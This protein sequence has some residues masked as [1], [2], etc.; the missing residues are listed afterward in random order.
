[1]WDDS[2]DD[3]EYQFDR[4]RHALAQL[5]QARGEGHAAA[6]VAVSHY[7]TDY[8]GDGK[9]NVILAV[10]AELYDI[11]REELSESLKDG[12][13]DIVGREAFDRITFRVLRPPYE[14]DW[15]AEIVRLL[16]RQWVQSERVTNPALN[17]A[18]S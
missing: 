5:L 15:V 9:W 13:A 11:A 7:S 8:V 17:S 3:R 14:S 16:D 12:C 18:T 2:D 1:M 10:P 4:D 6:I